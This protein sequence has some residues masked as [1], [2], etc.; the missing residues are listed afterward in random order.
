MRRLMCM[1]GKVALSTAREET[2]MED[3][4][5]VE[6]PWGD[7]AVADHEIVAALLVCDEGKIRDDSVFC[8]GVSDPRVETVSDAEKV[9]VAYAAKPALEELFGEFGQGVIGVFFHPDYELP[10]IVAREMKLTA[11]SADVRLLDHLV[12]M[13]FFDADTQA[14]T[15]KQK[16]FGRACAKVAERVREDDALLGKYYLRSIDEDSGFSA[17]VVACY[18]LSD[19]ADNAAIANLASE[20]HFGDLRTDGTVTL[21][22]DENDDVY[23]MAQDTPLCEADGDVTKEVL[24]LRSR[25]GCSQVVCIVVN[26]VADDVV[27]VEMTREDTGRATPEMAALHGRAAARQDNDSTATKQ[28]LAY[29][30]KWLVADQDRND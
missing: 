19:E 18:D 11:D 4:V 23:W 8:V 15:D 24:D 14:P 3:L 16:E 20:V 25:F 26:Y 29:Q 13:L 2:T 12:C 5:I 22:V 6:T 7:K 27:V 9:Q 1:H 28:K 17:K 10:A 30:A 21:V